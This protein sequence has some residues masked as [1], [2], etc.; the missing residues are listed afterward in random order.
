[1]KTRSNRNRKNM[2]TS[3]TLYPGECCDAT[4]HGLHDWHKRMF[5]ELGWMILA[6][7]YGMT[8]KTTVYKAGVARLHR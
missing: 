7:K 3:H 1:M 4:F 2:S 6:K 5:E 8:D